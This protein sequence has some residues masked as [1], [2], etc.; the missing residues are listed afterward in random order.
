MFLCVFVRNNVIC[1]YLANRTTVQLLSVK[2]V[3]ITLKNV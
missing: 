1:A 2:Y 3:Y